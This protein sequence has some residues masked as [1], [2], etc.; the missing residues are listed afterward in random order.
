MLRLGND[1]EAEAL[2]EPNTAP[3]DFTG[4]VINP[5]LY[6]HAPGFDG[7]KLED[8]IGRGRGFNETLPA[9]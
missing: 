8:W 9:K 5:L 1:L 2:H 7:A 3:R 4:R 6:V